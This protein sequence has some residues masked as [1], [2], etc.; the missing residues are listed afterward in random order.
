MITENCFQIELARLDLTWL[1]NLLG[2]IQFPFLGEETK[3]PLDENQIKMIQRN[4]QNRGLVL[5]APAKVWQVDGTLLVIAEIISNPE[6]LIE[7]CTFSRG[8]KGKRVLIYP[9]T[10]FPLFVE[11][12]DTLVFTIYA[13]LDELVVQQKKILHL[14]EKKESS[15]EVFSIPRTL[16][17]SVLQVSQNKIT[18]DM[19]EFGINKG[20]VENIAELINT[21]SFMGLRTRYIFRDGDPFLEHQDCILS[22]NNQVWIGN[23]L[24]NNQVI[25][26]NPMETAS[27][28]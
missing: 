28:H 1:G 22:N 20:E 21:F 24:G 27:F 25:V 8:G 15:G 9:S 17:P 18:E 3:A 23:F 16:I 11:V 13:Q 26:F 5:Y 7:I 6:V 4:M 12:S 10:D 2:Y 19:K 14:L